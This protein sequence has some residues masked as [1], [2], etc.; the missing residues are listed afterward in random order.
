MKIYKV[1][2]EIT[3]FG[4]RKSEGAYEEM[5]KFEGVMYFRNTYQLDK[6]IEEIYDA[7]ERFYPSYYKYG[8]FEITNYG[9]YS[10][11]VSIYR[12]TEEFRI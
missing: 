5:K 10:I 1:S 8:R 4:F 3:G 2:V 7:A 12:G 11:C 6:Y 9:N